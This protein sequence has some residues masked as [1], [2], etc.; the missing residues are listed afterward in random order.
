MH[1][2]WSVDIQYIRD[3]K[4]NKFK[5]ENIM[6]LSTSV[7]CTREVAKSLKIGTSGLEIEAREEDYTTADKKGIIPL[8]RVFYVYALIFIFLAA[9][10]NKLQLQLAWD[11]YA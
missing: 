8:F 11:K 10:G 1:K 4:K 6:K 2:Y 3:I 9:L 5:L 7:R